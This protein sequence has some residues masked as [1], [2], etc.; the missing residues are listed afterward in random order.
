MNRHVHVCACGRIEPC[1]QDADRCEVFT[2]YECQECL[3]EQMADWY[4][5]SGYV[6]EP[7]RTDEELTRHEKH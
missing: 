6:T 7:T 3:D 5:A 4:R 2:P 1:R